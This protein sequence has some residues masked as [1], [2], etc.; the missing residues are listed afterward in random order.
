MQIRCIGKYEMQVS[1]GFLLVFLPR[2]HPFGITE[3]TKMMTAH[4]SSAELPRFVR[5]NCFV[6]MLYSSQ[7]QTQCLV[8]LSS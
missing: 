1:H 5:R 2:M 4:L 6:F 3:K 7:D 8:H